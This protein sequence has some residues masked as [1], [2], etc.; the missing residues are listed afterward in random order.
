MT[1]NTRE[2]DMEQHSG[3]TVYRVN[4][5][6]AQAEGQPQRRVSHERGGQGGQG[7]Q[8]VKVPLTGEDQARQVALAMTQMNMNIPGRK[9]GTIIGALAGGAGGKSHF[10]V[11]LTWSV[12]TVKIKTG[13]SEVEEVCIYL[14]S[15]F[16][17]LRL[18]R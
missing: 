5:R 12:N 11:I 9:K 15:F 17:F 7:G 8:G 18:H 6:Q 4:A 10:K 2:K 3:Q 14:H 16:S 1:I 13:G